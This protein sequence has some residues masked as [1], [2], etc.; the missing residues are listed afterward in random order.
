MNLCTLYIQ[1]HARDKFIFAK[2][3]RMSLH[4]IPSIIIMRIELPCLHM[5]YYTKSRANMPIAFRDTFTLYPVSNG[6]NVGARCSSLA[7]FSRCRTAASKIPIILSSIKTS[8][9]RA[10]KEL[11]VVHCAKYHAISWRITCRFFF[12]PASLGEYYLSAEG[13]ERR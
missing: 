6:R 11:V 4:S 3:Y 9:R 1:K 7:G 13:T 8:R 5:A 10:T 12:P 2:M